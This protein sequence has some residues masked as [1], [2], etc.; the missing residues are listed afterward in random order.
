[1]KYHRLKTKLIST[2]MEKYHVCYS[3]DD[4]KIDVIY[5]PYTL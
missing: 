4:R 2:D 3:L 5:K 1:M